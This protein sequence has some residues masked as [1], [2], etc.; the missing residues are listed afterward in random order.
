MQANPSHLQRLIQEIDEVGANGVIYVGL[1]YCDQSGF[2]LPR[3]QTKLR[4]RHVP[5]LYI[6][7][8]YTATG[9][10]QLKVRIEAFAEMLS[11]EFEEL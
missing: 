10:A 4:E 1:K 6:E 7:H 8:D 2:E 11:N 9:L 3:L 5:F